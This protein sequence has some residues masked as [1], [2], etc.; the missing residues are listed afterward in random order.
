MYH[1]CYMRV[2]CKDGG[3]GSDGNGLWRRDEG[4]CVGLLGSRNG[5]VILMVICY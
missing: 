5:D 2:K 3:E 4:L 1:F